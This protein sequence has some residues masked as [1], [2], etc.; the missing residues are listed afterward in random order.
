MGAVLYGFYA[1]GCCKKRVYIHIY[2]CITYIHIRFTNKLYIHIIMPYIHIMLHIR[3]M[4]RFTNVH[5][6]KIRLWT[7]FGDEGSDAASLEEE[8]D[9]YAYIR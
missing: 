5:T 9:V 1:V 7:P 2:I 8:K 6:H 3:I 4:I